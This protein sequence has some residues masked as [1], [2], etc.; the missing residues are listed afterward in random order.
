MLSPENPY[1]STIAYKKNPWDFIFCRRWAGFIWAL[2]GPCLLLIQKWLFEK[3]FG[4]RK[5]VSV[6]I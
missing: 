1:N 3:A 5:V 4:V 6:L 2:I